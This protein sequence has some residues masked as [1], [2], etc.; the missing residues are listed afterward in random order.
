MF[1]KTIFAVIVI[2]TFLSV[3]SLTDNCWLDAYGRGVGKAIH[4]CSRD[5]YPDKSGLL[6]YPK[7]KEGYTGVGPV[8]WQN[9]P[10]GFRD[11]GAYCYKS[12]TS[13]GRGA[14]Y[15]SEKSCL[16]KHR[17]TGCEKN[18]LIWYPKCKNGFHN[19]ACCVCSA[20]C[21]AGMTDIG[22]SCQKSSY[23]RGAGVPLG[24]SKDQEYD[25]GLCYPPCRQTYTGI[26]PVCWGQC[27]SQ[28][29]ESNLCLGLCLQKETCA[30]HIREFAND[31]SKL[32][33]D[34]A[35]KNYVDVIVDVAKLVQDTVYDK[36]NKYTA[37]EELMFLN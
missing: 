5:D 10:D 4:D 29:K 14:G 24:C 36:C 9:C 30:G 20:D 21:P 15:T 18:G 35:N 33:E 7:C 11:D 13:Y 2:M 28:W 32:A 31:V 17:D 23:G 37:Y 1:K 3:K 6:C 12:T 26:G 22:I 27:P 8:C 19:V 25:T 34:F 16:E